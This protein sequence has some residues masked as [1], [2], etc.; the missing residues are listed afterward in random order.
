MTNWISGPMDL[1]S[2]DHTVYGRVLARCATCN[3]VA[4][5]REDGRPPSI[6]HDDGC[7]AGARWCPSEQIA[8]DGGDDPDY[9]A[10]PDQLAD[11][12]A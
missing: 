6:E 10:D 11:A 5:E 2:K 12:L 8:D 1:P 4:R 9:G 7:P 3:G